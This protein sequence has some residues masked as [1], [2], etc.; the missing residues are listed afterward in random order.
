MACNPNPIWGLFLETEFYWDTAVPIHLRAVYGCFHAQSRAER[1]RQSQ[2]LN[3]SYL[4]LHKKNVPIPWL[5][6]QWKRRSSLICPSLPPLCLIQ[7]LQ[8]QKYPQGTSRSGSAG[9]GKSSAL[10]GCGFEPQSRSMGSAT[11]QCFFSL[12]PSFPVSLSP[13][14][15]LWAW[16]KKK[17]KD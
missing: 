17:K 11:D 14:S 7:A 10:K 5:Y 8:I 9:W 1:L 3:Y 15:S 4:A 6:R 2:S 12:S 16:L 13:T